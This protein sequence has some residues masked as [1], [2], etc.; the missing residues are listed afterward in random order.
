[1]SFVVIIFVVYYFCFF[2]SYVYN[3]SFSSNLKI[4]EKRVQ[5]QQKLNAESKKVSGLIAPPQLPQV[6]M[7]RFI[8]H[9]EKGKDSSGLCTVFFSNKLSRTTYY[10]KI[11]FLDTM[12]IN[13]YMLEEEYMNNNVLS[14]SNPNSQN[15]GKKSN[16]FQRF[17]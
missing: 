7:S 11:M 1:M 4:Q 5:K 12:S 14:L 2:F 10:S 13:S 16:K 15:K 3:N 6:D 17:Y 9:R 8:I